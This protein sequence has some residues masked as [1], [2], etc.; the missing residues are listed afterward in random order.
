MQENDDT[1]ELFLKKPTSGF[2]YKKIMILRESILPHSKK[3]KY[4][5]KISIR[6]QVSLYNMFA[7]RVSIIFFTW[8]TRQHLNVY[9][10]RTAFWKY[11]FILI[12]K[13]LL[14]RISMKST[15]AFYTQSYFE[16]TFF[17]YWKSFRH[18]KKLIFSGRKMVNLEV[19][20]NRR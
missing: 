5:L 13:T 15:S 4:I 11:Q 2:R 12:S 20:R 3:G 6:R 8:K 18:W 16:Q 10:K 19:L 7:L 1:R 9:S 14:L 17:I